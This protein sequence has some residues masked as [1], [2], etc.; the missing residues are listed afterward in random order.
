MQVNSISNNSFGQK[1]SH[2]EAL[3]RLANADDRELKASSKQYA[4]M[5]LNGDKFRRKERMIYG[6]MPVAMGIAEV[7]ASPAKAV[8]ITKNSKVFSPLMKNAKTF[9]KTTAKW[10]AGFAL[11]DA[12][13]AGRN[14]IVDNSPALKKFENDHKFLSVSTTVLGGL[15]M[16]ALG[17]KALKK[18]PP[19]IDKLVN[20]K[21]VNSVKSSLLKLDTT[22]VNSKAF[23]SAANVLAKVPSP[24][25]SVL[26]GVAV[27]AP[28][29]TVVA[30]LVNSQR[31]FSAKHRV[32]N[33]TYNQLKA[34]QADAREI[35]KDMGKT[36]EA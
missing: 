35:L 12:L 8:T 7:A 32:A 18:L 25:K 11:V 15:V 14:K 29:L 1:I 5:A 36:E 21:L 26:T 20:P 33:E 31:F 13:V 16:L 30:Q 24:V 10:M 19:I 4:D 17:N 22:I 9:A 23:K 27:V 28:L 34:A 6:L 3:E 2:K